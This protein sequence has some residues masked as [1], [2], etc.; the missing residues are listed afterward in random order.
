MSKLNFLIAPD[1]SPEYFTGWH[2]LSTRLQR[3]IDLPIHLILPANATE[4]RQQIERDNVDLIYTNPF[5]TTDLVRKYGY[6]PVV[7]P[8]NHSDETVIARGVESTVNSFE[9]IKPGMTVAYTDN[10]DVKLVSLRLLEAVDISEKDLTWLHVDSFSSV[11]RSLIQS[12]ADIGLFMSSAYHNLTKFTRSQLN[13]LIES[14]IHDLSHVILIHPRQ[15]E[16]RDQLQDI[17]SRIQEEP[18]GQLILNDLG[19]QDGFEPLSRDKLELLIDLIETL[20]D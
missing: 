4:E 14:Q 13:L 6:L 1:F 12:K 11:A 15:A 7:I 9:D 19:L 16:L 18:S 10:L 2:F 20:R 3:M 8:K 5:D 17:F